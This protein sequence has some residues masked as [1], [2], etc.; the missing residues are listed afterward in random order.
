MH[1]KKTF[2]GMQQSFPELLENRLNIESIDRGAATQIEYQIGQNCFGGPTRKCQCLGIRIFFPFLIGSWIFDWI[3]IIHWFMEE[4]LK[5]RCTHQ[6]GEVMEVLWWYGHYKTKMFIAA[7][8]NFMVKLD[9]NEWNSWAAL[10]KLN[11]ILSRWPYVQFPSRLF[12]ELGSIYC[13]R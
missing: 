9:R 7:K 4:N 12:A 5:S 13:K 2:V 6:K 10:V 3:I 1:V 8:C 11:A